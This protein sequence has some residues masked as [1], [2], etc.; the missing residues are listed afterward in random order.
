MQYVSGVSTRTQ[1]WQ[2]MHVLGSFVVDV[3]VP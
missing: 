1:V 3:T 2:G